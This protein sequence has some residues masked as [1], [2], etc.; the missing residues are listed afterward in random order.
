MKKIFAIALAVV[1]VLSI[2]SVAAAFN[3]GPAASSG[4]SFGYGID[5]IKYTRSTGEIGSSY[6]NA[7]D[8]ATAVNGADVYFAIKLTVPDL[9]ATNDIRANAE[10]KIDAT[11]ISG[12]DGGTYDISDLGKGTYYYM[13]DAPGL[14]DGFYLIDAFVAN[15]RWMN[16]VSETPVFARYCLDTDTAE[17]Y[18][19]VTS[20]RP[21]GRWFTVGGYDIGKVLISENG[22]DANVDLG[23]LAVQ[24]YTNG[25]PSVAT[26]GVYQINFTGSATDGNWFAI[27]SD[28]NNGA[29]V[30]VTIGKTASIPLT[31]YDQAAGTT[32]HGIQTA[33]MARTVI[34]KLGGE[35]AKVTIDGAEYELKLAG[36]GQAIRLYEEP[37]HNNNVYSG[38]NNMAAIAAAVSVSASSAFAPDSAEVVEFREASTPVGSG[39]LVAVVPLDANDKALDVIA[40]AAEAADARDAIAAVYAGESWAG[41]KA[42][43]DLM[44]WLDEGNSKTFRDAVAAGEVYFTDSNLRT[45]FGFANKVSDSITWKANSTPI[46]LDPTVSIPKTGDNASVIGFAMIMV[47]VVAAAVA[48]RKVNA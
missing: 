1:M 43:T 16:F 45:A 21:L 28:P 25:N 7:D 41:T 20:D 18:A 48:V 13:E 44:A 19:E 12:F 10:V 26:Q 37:V 15:S 36:N 39:D 40:N 31:K 29:T 24:N 5:V 2:A 42:V 22:V 30:N 4:D 17:V 9:L 11:A 3:W 34:D 38:V 46:I 47:A 32:T 35:G 27:N 14:A 33:A 8:A 23:S 6:F